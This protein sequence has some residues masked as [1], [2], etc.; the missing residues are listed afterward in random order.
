MTDVNLVFDEIHKLVKEERQRYDAGLN[1]N[2]QLTA[3]AKSTL[4]KVEADLS[5]LRS[6]Y[7]QLI[8]EAQRP[9]LST[10]DVETE[11][12][13][14]ELKQFV[15]FVRSGK[16]PEE[17][18]INSF[19]DEDGGFLVPPSFEK[20]LIV[21][22]Y[23][24]A[25][26]RPECTT[27]KTGKDSI[28]I[29]QMGQIKMTWGSAPPVEQDIKAGQV[30]ATVH[31]LSGFVRLDNDTLADSDHDIASELSNLFPM[32]IA[33]AEDRG[34]A[35]GDGVNGPEGI[36]TNMSVLDKALESGVSGELNDSSHNGFDILLDMLATLKQAY[37]KNA[38]WMFNS[39]TE[40]KLR[41][42]KT[43]EGSYLWQPPVMAGKPPTLLGKKAILPEAAP[44]VEAGK[45]AIVL[46]NL[47][48]GYV[49]RDRKNMTIRRD[50][51]KYFVENQTAIYVRKRTA[52]VVSLPEAFI[53]L[54]ISV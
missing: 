53:G 3:E 43:T 17:R 10:L 42:I 12:D 46:G 37:K 25:S 35:V 44:N 22:A 50:G 40:A 38:C 51:S 8:I 23:N 15:E 7:D 14:R 18:A 41:K 20:Q 4:E 27:N 24:L 52:G 32:A 9:R 21:K 28:K 34:F 29:P 6:K 1:D 11:T 26:I 16:L 48:Y 31:P 36:F 5:E 30:S 54:K 45:L 49:I 39:L 19:S 47:L 33:D 2:K 13:V